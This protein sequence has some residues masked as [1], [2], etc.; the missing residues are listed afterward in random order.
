MAGAA[1]EAMDQVARELDQVR[2][3]QWVASCQV[4]VSADWPTGTGR[5][6]PRARAMRRE[7]GWG[8]FSSA[9]QTVLFFEYSGECHCPVQTA[10]FCPVQSGAL[11]PC[12]SGASS[13]PSPLQ[14]RRA[15]L[16]TH[17]D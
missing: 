16:Q 13:P 1:K 2:C 5:H 11:L 8:V 7:R 6:A 17:L 4:S 15:H 14:V 9:R 10:H 12:Q 3:L